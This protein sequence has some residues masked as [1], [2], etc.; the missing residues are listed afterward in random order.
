MNSLMG[1]SIVA[2]HDRPRQQPCAVGDGRGGKGST[3]SYPLSRGRFVML[4]GTVG[5]RPARNRGW[6][7]ALAGQSRPSKKDSQ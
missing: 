3:R 7:P 6:P 2:S 4:P 1:T 5:L